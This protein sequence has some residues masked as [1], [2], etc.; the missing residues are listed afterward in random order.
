MKP[1][2]LLYSFEQVVKL[3]L[4][5]RCED[6]ASEQLNYYHTGKRRIPYDT[7]RWQIPDELAEASFTLR[8]ATP[9]TM[10]VDLYS[11]GTREYHTKR[12]EY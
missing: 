10:I 11:D 2:S 7:P 6:E 3:N 8:R 5:P 1:R 4:P 12:N 9:V